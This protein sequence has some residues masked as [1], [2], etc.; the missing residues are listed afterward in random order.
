MPVNM[1]QVFSDDKSSEIKKLMKKQEAKI[2]MKFM[3]A[4]ESLG[5][6]IKD[7][8]RG[9]RKIAERVGDLDQKVFGNIKRTSESNT[10]RKAHKKTSMELHKKDKKDKKK[11]N[12]NDDKFNSV[13]S[14]GSAASG[15]KPY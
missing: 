9:L 8:A 5:E 1:S 3:S 10:S 13:A 12:V 6:L 14:R 7:Q 2:N 4:V 15:E 11:H